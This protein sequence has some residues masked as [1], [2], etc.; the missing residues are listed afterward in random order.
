M[1]SD[2]TVSGFLRPTLSKIGL[3]LM[4]PAVV[5]LLVTRSL[6][7]TIDIYFYLLT[8]RMGLWTGEGIV[9]VF[10]MWTLLWIPFYLAACVIKLLIKSR[11]Q[12]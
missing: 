6:E 10:N 4:M 12:P 5:R 8:P 7:N 1:E 11:R 9:Y 3:T 2:M